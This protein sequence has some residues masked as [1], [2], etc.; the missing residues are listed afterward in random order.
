VGH[1]YRH[2]RSACDPRTSVRRIGPFRRRLPGHPFSSPYSILSISAR[3]RCPCSYCDTVLGGHH[4]YQRRQRRHAPVSSSLPGFFVT[5]TLPDVNWNIS[6]LSG[7][8]QRFPLYN[9]VL[10]SCTLLHHAA[11]QTPCR[12]SASTKVL[13]IEML[14]I[15]PRR[16]T[17][18]RTWSP[19][20]FWTGRPWLY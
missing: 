14:G 6:V 7:E 18:S 15:T 9:E 13:D 4:R 2:C 11:T 19:R 8:F 17:H 1:F 10:R 16:Q 12:R 20:R 3:K 5:E